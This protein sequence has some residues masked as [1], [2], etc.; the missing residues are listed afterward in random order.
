MTGG[1]RHA[2][3][4]F[5]VHLKVGMLAELQY[6]TDTWARLVSTVVLL[7]SSL[8]SIAIVY[9]HVDAIQ[10]WTSSDLIVVVGSF[11]LLGSVTNGIIHLSMAELASD[12]KKGT[13]D[14]RLLKPVDSQVLALVQ[15]VDAWRVLDALTGIGLIAWGML[16]G[17]GAGGGVLASA[18]AVLAGLAMLACGLLIVAGFWMLITSVAFW[19]IQGEG[20][21]W[22][23][24]DM[25][26][27]LRWPISIFGPGLRIALMT[28]FPAGLAVTVPAQALTG[29]LDATIGLGA[30]AA[31]VAFVGG[32]RIAWRAALRR[33]EGASG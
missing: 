10:G 19:T 6:R 15:K 14:F 22:A 30:V 18:G 26:D 2:L 11:F 21:L 33:Y 28:I 13:L 3:R 32:S 8:A 24:D 25:F 5:W 27:H 12:I 9:A 29:R 7:V 31:A 16:R 23:L 20:I 17:Q 4:V 1:T